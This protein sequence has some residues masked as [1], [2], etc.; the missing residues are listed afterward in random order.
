MC[1]FADR[2]GDAMAETT[3]NFN[4]MIPEKI[5]TPDQVSTRLGTL[6]FFDGMPTDAT[7]A[8]LLDHLTF[9]RGVQ[10]FL[11]TVQVASLESVRVGLAEVGA[12]AAN[13]VVIYDDLM[14]S[15]SLFLTGNTDTVYALAMLELDHDGPTVVEIPPVAGR[16]P[17]MTPGSASSWTWAHLVPIEGRGEVFDP[18]TRIRRPRAR[19]VLLGAVN[20]LCQPD[21]SARV[22][23]QRQH[24]GGVA[25][26][27]YGGEG[28]ST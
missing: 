10:V 14:D 15:S 16:E 26:V 4:T 18:A 19:R 3:P 1:R 9:I 28:L 21:L 24:R 11:N 8:T 17:S 12:T 5:M 23:G 6:E 20:Q 25:D 13:Q 2:E 22:L 7:A 27:P